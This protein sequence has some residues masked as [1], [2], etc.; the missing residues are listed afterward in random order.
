MFAAVGPDY[1]ERMYVCMYVPCPSALDP[2]HCQAS[3][4]MQ[5]KLPRLCIVPVGDTQYSM[6]D[7]L[8]LMGCW[9]RAR[10]RSLSVPCHPDAKP[11]SVT[12]YEHTT[13]KCRLSLRG[14]LMEDS[15]GRLYAEGRGQDPV[16]IKA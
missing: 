16:L 6:Q 12:T 10:S 1:V 11:K 7:T 8:V 4:R 5:R 13:E 15:P 3:T 14:G 9:P 2:D